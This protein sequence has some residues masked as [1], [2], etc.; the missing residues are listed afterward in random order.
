VRLDS[1]FAGWE[2]RFCIDKTGQ[3]AVRYPLRI[4]PSA[5]EPIAFCQA[6]IYG[7]MNLTTLTVHGLED[8]LYLTPIVA[9]RRVEREVC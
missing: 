3:Y 5:R 2:R 9:R 1:G 4:E 8:S 7:D 6:H